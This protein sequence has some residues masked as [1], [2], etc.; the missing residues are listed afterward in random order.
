MVFDTL[1]HLELYLPLVARLQTVIEV[2][3][4]GDVYDKP[5][6]FYHTNVKEVT[7]TIVS[8]SPCTDKKKYLV[9]KKTTDIMIVLEGEELTAT[10]W[11]EA[12]KEGTPYDEK[13]DSLFVEGEPLAVLKAAVGRFSIFLPGE[14]HKYGVSEDTNPT[15]TKKVIF[16]VL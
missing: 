13:T 5:V 1:E 7:Y 11:R 9:R 10:T 3:D 8:S 15:T 2:M 6:G 16:S 4:K 12:V 14:P